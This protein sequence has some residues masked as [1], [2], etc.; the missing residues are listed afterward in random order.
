MGLRGQ[1]L[2]FLAIIAGVGGPMSAVMAQMGGLKGPAG[3]IFILGGMWLPGLAALATRLI[4]TRSLRGMGW[5]AGPR[6]YYLP[7]YLLPLIYGGA[8]FVIAAAGGNGAWNPGAWAGIAAAHGLPAS[9]TLG[10]AVLLSVNVLGNLAG[11]VG[12]EIGWRGF[13]VPALA[14]SF[15][16][17]GVAAISWAIWYGFHL[18]VILAGGYRPADTPLWM[19]LLAFGAM[20]APV[21]AMMAWLRL[22]SGSL[23]PAALAHA[24]HNAFILDLFGPAMIPGRLTPWLVAEF[25]A[26]TP[27]AALA[28][29]GL[30]LW[31]AGVPE[32]D[33]GRSD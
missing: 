22:K 13:L 15:G 14:K 33:R 10:L 18:P 19:S 20:L 7:A 4:A 26:I 24:A 17:W 27:V 31:T 25:G 2:L 5:G 11:A 30:L 12:E 8:P 28:V 29:V 6:R 32:T 21:S 16:F 1:I 9:E 23:W 3:P